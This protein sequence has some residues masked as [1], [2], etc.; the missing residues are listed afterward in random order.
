MVC[1]SATRVQ[2]ITTK[3]RFCLNKKMIQHK[4][5]SYHV[6]VRPANRVTVRHAFQVLGGGNPGKRSANGHG[7]SGRVLSKFYFLLA[8]SCAMCLND[9]D[10]FIN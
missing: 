2:N 4:G 6:D 10:Y 7:V 8:F 1:E 3:G 5:D 9:C